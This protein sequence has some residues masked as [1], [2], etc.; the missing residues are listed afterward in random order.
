MQEQIKE[1]NRQVNKHSNI[2]FYSVAAIL[3]LTVAFGLGQCTAPVD[4][5]AI[6]ESYTD[7]IT[8]LE[9]QLTECRR[10]K[11]VDCDERISQCHETERA[12][13]QESLNVFRERCE[14]LACQE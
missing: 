8:E 7:D 4:R 14:Q 5:Q 13:C 11:V 9:G 3:S 1:L 2:I 6:C 12:A 10:L